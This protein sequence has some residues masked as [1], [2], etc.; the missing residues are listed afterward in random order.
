MLLAPIISGRR[1]EHSHIF[2]ELISLGFVRARIDGTI[3]DLDD[4][5]DLDKNKQ[6]TIEVVVDRLRSREDIKT[7]LA[8]SLETAIQASN[9]LVT[10]TFIDQDREDILFSAKFCC[11]ICQHSI[12]ELEPRSF[13]F[14]NPAGACKT[15]DGL[16][17][18][19]FFDPQNIIQND[20]LS[21]SEGA[22]YGLSL[23]H[24]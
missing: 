6:H 10:V 14:N 4:L 11:P 3:T 20:E 12:S 21:L 17:L 16:G 22:I 1:G 5:P 7:R 23:I 9:G 13:S 24:I 19:Q 2:K 8:D 15:C 18:K